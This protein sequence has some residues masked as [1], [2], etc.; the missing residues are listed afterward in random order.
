MIK[1]IALASA[2]ISG[3]LAENGLTQVQQQ[4]LDEQEKYMD[5]LLH[6][7]KSNANHQ[8]IFN[9]LNQHDKYLHL[10]H[11]HG[12]NGETKT[13]VDNLNI[14]VPSMVGF[15]AGDKTRCEELS[16]DGSI[17][18]EAGALAYCQ[19]QGAELMLPDDYTWAYVKSACVEGEIELKAEDGSYDNRKLFRPDVSWDLNEHPKNVPAQAKKGQY[20][21]NMKDGDGDGGRT[22]AKIHYFGKFANQVKDVDGYFDINE[23]NMYSQ[24][25]QANAEPG[26][27]PEGRQNLDLMDCGDVGDPCPF[28]KESLLASANPDVTDYNAAYL[29]R[30]FIAEGQNQDCLIFRCTSEAEGFI[31]GRCDQ[32]ENLPLCTFKLNIDYDLVCP[33]K[34]NHCGD[35]IVKYRTI[36]DGDSST[37]LDTIE[38]AIANTDQGNDEAVKEIISEMK[39]NANSG[40]YRF[41]MNNAVEGEVNP[42]CPCDPPGDLDCDDGKCTVQNINQACCDDGLIFRPSNGW[43]FDFVSGTSERCVQV[44]HRDEK[45]QASSFQ[46]YSG[47]FLWQSDAENKAAW[48]DFPTTSFNNK[49]VWQDAT[50]RALDTNNQFD[51]IIRGECLCP[52]GFCP[53]L[54]VIANGA[55]N[56]GT[57]GS[58]EIGSS[59]TFSCNAGFELYN[60]NQK[61]DTNSFKSD[62]LENS[63]TAGC[64][65]SW[66][67]M[68][69]AC[70][71]GCPRPADKDH[72]RHYYTPS[73][74]LS[75]SAGEVTT[76]QCDSGYDSFLAGTDIKVDC[77]Q[78]ERKCHVNDQGQTVLDPLYCDCRP[79][80]CPQYEASPG[81]RVIS[82]SVKEA[83]VT[84]DDT[85]EFYS[86]E[87]GTGMWEKLQ[88]LDGIWQAPNKPC[89]KIGCKNPR[90]FA[91]LLNLKHTY[92]SLD[93][94]VTAEAIA[95][96]STNASFVDTF[97]ISDASA[98]NKFNNDN[99]V[100]LDDMSPNML[101]D[102][103]VNV[104]PGSTFT[105]TC[106]RGFQ[107]FNTLGAILRAGASCDARTGNT[108]TAVCGDHGVWETTCV[109]RCDEHVDRDL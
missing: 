73:S 76:F 40:N 87:F 68:S 3:I 11:D 69:L 29:K 52:E 36:A 57:S 44:S 71:A 95:I 109:C 65:A 2:S 89:Q 45:F 62:C 28:S 49:R 104:R 108:C 22:N 7:D 54:P 47:V 50:G 105:T 98:E 77:N 78:C 100:F 17:C 39:T 16:G 1:S 27:C 80:L 81:Y 51:G 55:W 67:P 61:L 46:S 13:Y 4:R 85:N 107:P 12:P 42:T 33:E 56:F 66:S 82:Q 20:W 88:C 63:V 25:C 96:G 92:K 84:C 8:Q 23:S 9:I 83:I 53:A 5:K 59:Y 19:E 79:T 6:F 90:D 15:F 48:A 58:V 41:S 30:H 101:A 74:K 103:V 24:T 21:L 43:Q 102:P 34:N 14:M 37:L 72:G 10:E 26:I 70:V 64:G 106:K 60:F 97:M 38:D 99:L 32:V 94:L 31:Q 75:M 91:P 86:N 35:K 93:K 18:T